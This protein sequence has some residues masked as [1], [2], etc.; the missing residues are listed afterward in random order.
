MNNKKQLSLLPS[1]DNYLNKLALLVKTSIRI[2]VIL[3]FAFCILVSTLVGLAASPFFV[4]EDRRLDFTEGVVTI[5]ESARDLVK[6]FNQMNQ[7]INGLVLDLGNEDPAFKKK[8]LKRSPTYAKGT[9]EWVTVPYDRKSVYQLTKTEFIQYL[10]NKPKIQFNLNTLITNSDG[11]V[12][13]RAKGI[14]DTQI[15]LEN[16]MTNAQKTLVGKDHD[17]HPTITKLY[18]ITLDGEKNY[19]IVSG[20]PKSTTVYIK[21]TGVTPYLLG[22]VTFIICFYLITKR[23]MK[24]IEEIALGLM[25]IAKGNLNYRIREKSKDELGSLATNIN[26]MAFELNEMIE[27]QRQTEKLKDELIT[28]VSHDLRTP[29]TSIMGYLRLVKDHQYKSQTQLD[30]YVDIAYGKSEQLKKLIEDLFDFTRLNYEGVQLKKEKVSLNQMIRQLMDELDPIANDNNVKFSNDLP[31]EQI[32]MK[33]D[34]NQMVRALEN[35][36]TNAIKYSTPPGNI[37]VKMIKNKQSVQISVS[38]PCETLTKE[39]VTRLFDRFYRVDTSRSSNKSGAGL[40]LAITK[41]IIELHRGTIHV[42]YKNQMIELT[43]VLPFHEDQ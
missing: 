40:G 1:S 5:D 36:L 14:S 12:L 28:N 10:I 11:K 29:L 4:N 25:E 7:D 37:Y 35:V 22:L 20:V 3:A 13:Y 8:F 38:N 2:Q 33:I 9:E 24:E 27:R 42:D 31:K 16:V 19:I 39:E 32:M 18:S 41:S 34:P 43:I 15:N 23:K 6:Q 30:E 21:E 17:E 26:Y